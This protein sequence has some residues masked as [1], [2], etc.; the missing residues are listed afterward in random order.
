[1]DILDK[2]IYSDGKTAL[3]MTNNGEDVTKP[4]NRMRLAELRKCKDCNSKNAVLE[5]K[6]HTATNQTRSQGVCARHWVKLARSNIGW[7]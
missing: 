5:I 4:L 7:D 6:F 1:M 2:Y 3:P